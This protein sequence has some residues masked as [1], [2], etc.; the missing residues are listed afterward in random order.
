[1]PIFACVFVL[2]DT[3]SYYIAPTGLIITLK[4]TLSFN[5]PSTLLASQVL[6]FRACATT[7]RLLLCHRECEN[8]WTICILQEGKAVI[9]DA[10]VDWSMT[11]P[12]V[13]SASRDIDTQAPNDSPT[14][15]MHDLW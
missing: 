4:T 8:D 5:L 9:G 2:L 3:E 1:M 10:T 6:R 7:H 13:N 15:L 14:A 12:T 11:H